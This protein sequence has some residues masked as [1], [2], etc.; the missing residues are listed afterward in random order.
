MA[1]ESL[2]PD[3]DPLR[4]M[5]WCEWPP[6]AGR[7]RPRT[8]ERPTPAPASQE[9]RWGCSWASRPA[10]RAEAAGRAKRLAGLHPQRDQ[11]PGTPELAAAWTHTVGA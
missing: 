6:L 11:L 10:V 8:S 5:N 2:D 7:L 1:A 4:G 3:S 9:R